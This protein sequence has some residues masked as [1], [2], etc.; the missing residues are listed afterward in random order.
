[1]VPGIDTMRIRLINLYSLLYTFE[2]EDGKTHYLR[3]QEN[4]KDG[5]PPD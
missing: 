5:L 1:M 3:N 2:A 4:D